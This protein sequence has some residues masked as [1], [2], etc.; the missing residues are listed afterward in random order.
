VYASSL[1]GMLALEIRNGLYS[2]RN[3]LVKR[4]IDLAGTAVVGLVAL[5]VLLLIYLWVRLDSRGPAF[6]RSQ[7]LGEN[8]GEFHCLKFR[9]MYI[10]ADERLAEIMASDDAIRNEYLRFHKLERDPRVT[11][12]GR[13]LRRF[14]LDELPQLLNVVKGEMSL[15]GPRPYMV[16]E[17]ADMGRY[18]ET[19]LRAKPGI[20][21]YWQITGRSN[22]TFQD[23][24]E[25]ESHY[26]RNWSI[27]WDVI[28]LVNTLA[29]VVR[30][31][32]AA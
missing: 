11:R 12:A 4:A 7:R 17:L 18:S 8:G 29:A 21:G 13:L 28:V 15:V 3:R 1:D 25:M 27:W 31:D 6:Y 26:V 10:D 32:G 16:R 5:P 9:T 2:R 24:L 20:T 19:I 22:V 23:R 14:S 30:R